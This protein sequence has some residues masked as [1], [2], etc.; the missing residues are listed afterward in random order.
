MINAGEKFDE[1]I[2]YWR[3]AK[4]IGTALIPFPINDKLM[5]LGVL[6]RIYARSPTCNTLIIV[7]DFNIRRDIINFLTNQENQEENNSEFKN[8]LSDNHIKIFI[9]DYVISRKSYMNQDLCILYELDSICSD[10]VDVI[11]HSKFK[12]IVLNKILNDSDDMTTIYRICP[13][14]PCFKQEEIDQIRTSTPVEETLIG[15]NIPKDSDIR[16]KL[17]HYNE[18]ISTSITVFGSFDIIQSCNS[19]DAKLNISANQVCYQIA[20]NNGWNEH[21]DMSIELYRKLDELYN[22]MFLKERASNTFNYIRERKLLLSDYEGKLDSIYKIVQDNHDKKILIINNRGE[23]ASIVT[24]YINDNY[25]KTICMDYH[26]KVD[27]IPAV[28][29]N[30]NPI[31][32][33]SGSKKGQQKTMGVKAQQTYVQRMFNNDNI[34]VISTNNSPNKDLF[35][36]V[37]IVIITSPF[38]KEIK[39]YIYRLSKVYFRNNKVE[40]YTLYCI[41]TIEQKV[42]DSRKPNSNH[43]V[44]NINEDENYSDFVIVD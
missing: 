43:I 13:L 30:G 27:D 8:L 41:G 18:Y 10:I 32:Y 5:V 28:D 14:I 23:F 21:L 20:Y 24:K 26:D 39:S 9:Y 6:Q 33:K 4:G 15:I 16:K 7:N 1:A 31:V 17:E 2:N 40:L 25:G 3:N 11:N 22:P 34:N 36:D 42:L 35:I 19:G 38:C 29:L 44:K 12:L 37:D